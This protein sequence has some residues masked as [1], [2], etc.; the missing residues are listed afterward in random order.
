M[1]GLATYS[2]RNVSLNIN[3]IPVVFEEVTFAR[4]T[5]DWSDASDADGLVVRNRLS[6]TRGTITVT[7]SDQQ[8]DTN[9]RLELLRTLDA[10][11]LTGFFSVQMRDNLGQDFAFSGFSWISKP[12]DMTKGAE[13]GT[14]EWPIRTANLELKNLGLSRV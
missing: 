12:P 1:P 7:V 9:T 2:R 13:A 5:D 3:F 6:D 10:S 14:K 8:Q 4:D 11:S